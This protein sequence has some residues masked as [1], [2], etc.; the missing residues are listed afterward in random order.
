ALEAICG[1][2]KYLHG[3]AIAIGQMAAA[4]LSAV[5]LG[6]STAE[7]ERIR[8]LFERSGLPTQVKLKAAQRKTLFAAMKLDKK[9]SDG[10]VRFVLAERIGR[11]RFGQT[12]T[13]KV[14]ESTLSSALK[15]RKS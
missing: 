7:V 10:E 6:L 2:G 8:S 3:E 4:S 13:D 14:I 12:V 11:V 1:Y 15:P 5:V 9:V